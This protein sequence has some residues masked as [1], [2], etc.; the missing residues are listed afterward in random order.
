MTTYDFH[1]CKQCGERNALP[2]YTL[3]LETIFVCG[4]CGFHYSD[5]LDDVPEAGG[6]AELELSPAEFERID[7]TIRTGL[8]SR[9]NRFTNHVNLVKRFGSP[10]NLKVLDIGCGGGMFLHLLQTEGANVKAIEPNS[11]RAAFA[12]QRFG[13]DVSQAPI[14]SPI[15]Q[16][17]AALSFDVVTMWDVIEHVNFP[18]QTLRAA[19]AVLRP[20]GILLMD[21]PCRDAF[22]YRT[23]ELTYRLSH[24]RFPTLLKVLYNRRPFGHKQILS[25]SD[26]H[27]L[28]NRVGATLLMLETIHEL[29][30]PYRMYLRRLLGSDRLAGLVEPA[31]KVAIS[32]APVRNKMLIALQRHHPGA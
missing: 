28:A 24:G 16:R 7:E 12:R 22:Y 14:E 13:L 21:T 2:T 23:G 26:I 18:L 27:W 32:A 15:W 25:K 17:N 20:G 29:S 4:S 9:E 10:G 31:A 6:T 30:Y 1:V 19:M 3:P 8:E 11:E 5:Y